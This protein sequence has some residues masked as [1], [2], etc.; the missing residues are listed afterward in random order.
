M[1]QFEIYE[2][3]QRHAIWALVSYC[4]CWLLIPLFIGW[5]FNTL[6][7]I[8]LI[9][10]KS[11]ISP[12]KNAIYYVMLVMSILAYFT[13]ITAIV[14]VVLFA[15]MKKDFMQPVNNVENVDGVER[16]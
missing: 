10:F 12:D 9:E 3:A 7:L 13:L 4:F 8:K 14:N 2:K 16:V 1:T 15:V 6:S 11:Y 5:I